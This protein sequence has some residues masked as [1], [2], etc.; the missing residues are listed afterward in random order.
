MQ[1]VC[2]LL[3]Y[4]HAPRLCQLYVYLANLHRL[5]T[6]IPDCCHIMLLHS[7]SS[8]HAVTCIHATPN[9]PISTAC[10][11]VRLSICQLCLAAFS[12]WKSLKWQ[13]SFP[14]TPFSA[15]MWQFWFSY[16]ANERLQKKKKTSRA[17]FNFN[18]HG[19]GRSKALAFLWMFA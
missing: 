19:L 17:H 8:K 15:F 4:Y 13:T 11:S 7:Y 3:S 14:C 16:F 18:R 12:Y 1:A 10:L 2:Y 9:S 5:K 6:A